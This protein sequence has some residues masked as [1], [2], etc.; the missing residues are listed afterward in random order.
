[1]FLVIFLAV[2]ELI[3]ELET[4]KLSSDTIKEV[5]ETTTYD[6]NFLQSEVVIIA[7]RPKLERIPVVNPKPFSS[8]NQKDVEILQ[9]AFKKVSGPATIRNLVAEYKASQSS[10]KGKTRINVLHEFMSTE[11]TYVT[12]L[13]KA[14]TFWLRPLQA[15]V[16]KRTPIIS[17]HDINV[18]FSTVETIIQINDTLLAKIQQRL[19][20]FPSETKFGDIFIS[21]AQTLKLYVEYVNK[22]DLSMSTYA[23][24]LK[25]NVRFAEFLNNAKTTA[26][27]NLDLAS[28][29]IMPVQRIPRYELL[30]REL[31]KCTNEMHTD[32]SNL[33]KAQKEIQSINQYINTQ[34]LKQDTNR[35]LLLAE[36]KIISNIPL[37]LV[38]PHRLYIHD[39]KVDFLHK[40]KRV[41]GHLYLMNDVVIITKYSTTT[42]VT[43]NY[44]NMFSLHTVTFREVGG[45]NFSLLI[46]TED[47]MELF[48]FWCQ[49]HELAKW[50]KEFNEA[51]NTYSLKKILDISGEIK[52]DFIILDAKYGVINKIDQCKDVTDEILNI[53]KL[54]GGDQ[55]ILK[56][57]T[58]SIIFGNPSPKAKK[59]LQITAQVKGKIKVRAFHD[60]DAVNVNASTF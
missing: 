46:K 60:M 38:V 34:K 22:F 54:Q 35:K 39:G 17:E 27:S 44:I 7:P 56:A 18:V 52:K 4:Q 3:A 42:P 6:I 55:L 25:N 16:K 21:S 5:M 12:S 51:I 45:D 43:H 10:K 13:K 49:P 2:K 59:Q 1:M 8:Y 57:E 19:S 32:W 31:I 29:L 23:E 53:V 14:V 40:M 30:L 28:I 37:A 20:K 36:E 11:E 58:K 15:E 47:K 26:Q 24:L 50:T 9:A 33:Q 48:D 41:T